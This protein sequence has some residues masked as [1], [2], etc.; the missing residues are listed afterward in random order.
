MLGNISKAESM[1]VP[2]R[3]RVGETRGSMTKP[4]EALEE[5]MM[6]TTTA[7]MKTATTMTVKTI[8]M[9]QPTILAQELE[10]LPVQQ[11]DQAQ[12]E[13]ALT[14]ELHLTLMVTA[15]LARTIKQASNSQFRSEP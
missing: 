6:A 11:K 14:E 5:T 12:A 3:C 8:L 2:G 10:D 9:T 15:S 4:I 13:V 1:V 7:V